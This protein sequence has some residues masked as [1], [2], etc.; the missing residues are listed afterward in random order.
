MGRLRRG[1]QRKKYQYCWRPNFWWMES[2]QTFPPRELPS[3]SWNRLVNRP[4]FSIFMDIWLCSQIRYLYGTWNSKPPSGND[5]QGRCL[6]RNGFVRCTFSDKD[7]FQHLSFQW[8][9]T[10]NYK[11]RRC[12]WRYLDRCTC[13]IRTK[14]TIQV[15]YLNS[16]CDGS[17]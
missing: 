5:S 14:I 13:G 9:G 6:Y 2:D 8:S 10:S 11:V 7:K 15:L 16:I 3:Y 4:S 12:H 17:F 1:S